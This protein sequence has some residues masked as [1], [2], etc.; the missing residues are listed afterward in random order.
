MRTAAAAPRF[1]VNPHPITQ[2]ETANNF[3]S[4]KNVLRRLHEV[5]LRIAQEAK[6]FARDFDDTFAEF[7]LRLNLF[8]TFGN[9]LSSLTGLPVKGLDISSCAGRIGISRR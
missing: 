6:T 3:G 1:S 2:A 4:Y 5:A 8:A 9:S 7:G